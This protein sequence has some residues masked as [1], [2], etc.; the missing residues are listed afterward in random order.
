MTPLSQ[1][2]HQ[3]QQGYKKRLKEW[4]MEQYKEGYEDPLLYPL[5]KSGGKNDA[6]IRTELFRACSGL[7]L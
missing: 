7:L 6:P 3:M 1:P 2:Q 4:Y 5:I